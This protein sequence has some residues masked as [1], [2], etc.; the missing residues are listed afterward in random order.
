[1]M[2]M[3]RLNTTD[4]PLY[5][6]ELLEIEPFFKEYVEL[7]GNLFELEFSSAIDNDINRAMDALELRRSLTNYELD[8]DDRPSFLEF[9][10]ALSQ[11]C[12]YNS[13]DKKANSFWI[14]ELLNNMGISKF[15]DQYIMH[16]GAMPGRIIN[17]ACDRVKHQMYDY[18]GR[19]GGLF[20]LRHPRKDMRDVEIWYQMHAYINERDY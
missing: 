20:P 5:F 6:A 10:I 1:M 12:A 19:N 16:T 11:R 18:D 17:R 2:E 8:P 3:M 15:S 4:N 7:A 14:G 13:L 9:L